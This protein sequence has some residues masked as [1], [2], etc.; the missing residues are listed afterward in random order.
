MTQLLQRLDWAL[1]A[2][3]AFDVFSEAQ[4][5]LVLNLFLAENLGTD[6]WLGHWS[7]ALIGVVMRVFIFLFG[8]YLSVWPSDGP[9]R[10]LVY[11]NM[12]QVVYLIVLIVVAS[13]GTP[14]TLIGYG[15]IL[16]LGLVLYAG[17]E[18]MGSV[19]MRLTIMKL[20]N[21]RTEDGTPPPEEKQTA[22]MSWAYSLGNIA[23]AAGGSGVPF[24]WRT[25][26][27]VNHLPVWYARYWDSSLLP[28]IITDWAQRAAHSG[29]AGAN[30]MC[31]A[32]GALSWC[33]STTL[34]YW[35]H[36]RL[37][38][39]LP[40]DYPPNRREIE[41]FL[42]PKTF[43]ELWASHRERLRAPGM[44]LYV[45]V[46][47][48][49]MFGVLNVFVD[50]GLVLPKYLIWRHGQIEWF[51]AFT[52]INPLL[53]PLLAPLV[54]PAIGKVTRGRSLVVI[55]LGTALQANA[56]IWA[57]GMP[58]LMGIVAFLVQFTI[59]EA[60]AM[61]QL[62]DYL[63]RL[64]GDPTLLPY[65]NAI[66]QLPLLVV[67]AVQTVLSGAL[68]DQY[69][70]SASQCPAQQQ[71]PEQLWLVVALIALT[72]PIAFVALGILTTT[73]KRSDDDDD[74]KDYDALKERE[75]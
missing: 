69:C 15:A 3:H 46:S 40:D 54:L 74:A 5:A 2:L 57:F 67:G 29:T 52:A 30:V 28:V 36:R 17:G 55:T 11:G 8:N 38:R 42:R 6:N 9:L 56:P 64:I 32:S 48:G 33:I 24:L 12:L 75:K 70:A 39:D 66:V 22:F 1:L 25:V 43:G 50:L 16:C 4:S 44:G 65:A 59:G 73:T 23:I 63:L 18:A 58:N 7:M 35:Y 71:R 47:A 19:A 51:P 37:A 68:L 49:V 53:I 45:L 26:F 27:S 61:P 31:L 10:A 34:L 13:I 72:T 21:R 60:L 20:A 62:G 14:L 41:A